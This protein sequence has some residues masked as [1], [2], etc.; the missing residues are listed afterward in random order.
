M[1]AGQMQTT[2]VFAALVKAWRARPRYILEEGGAR[3]GKTYAI[4]QLLH[5][6]ASTHPGTVISVVSETMPHLRRGAM[7]DF[8]NILQNLGVWDESRWA[9][10]A[11]IYTYP[12]GSF[13][14]FFSAD[15]PGKVLGPARDI[16]YANEGINIPWE[17]FRQLAVRTRDRIIV[18]YNPAH[19]FWAHEQIQPRDNAVTLRST[20]RDNSY[21][22][23]E[24]VAEIEAQRSDSRWWRVYGEGLVGELAGQIYAFEQ[25]DALPDATG[26]REFWGLDFGFTHDPTAL[27]HCLADTGRRILYAEEQIY[28]RALLNADIVARL[29][30]LGIPRGAA[31]YADCAE[32][33]SIAEIKRSGYNILSADKGAPVR[34]DK[35]RYQIQWLQGWQLRVTKAS[36]NAI[37]ELRNY[38]WASDADGHPLDYPIDNYNHWLDALRYGAWTHLAGN[39][40][41]YHISI[42]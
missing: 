27:A 11:S 8:K 40:G 17:V 15:Q 5:L 20:Y 4:L 41:Q 3:S 33:K 19:A 26:L 39:K 34:S 23:R 22:T 12:N 6:Y 31:I 21:L 35:L 16:L 18:D 2:P 25:I 36:V 10:V 30:G 14:E 37:R 38:V 1:A 29:H 28:E 13:I 32:P 42:R 7:R 9:Q 24:Q